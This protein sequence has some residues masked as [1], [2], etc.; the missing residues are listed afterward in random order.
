MTK[1]TSDQ[2]WANGTSLG[3][4]ELFDRYGDRVVRVQITRPNSDLANGTAFHIGGGAYVTARHVMEGGRNPE[5][6]G[7]RAP[8]CTFDTCESAAW[9]GHVLKHRAFE[10]DLVTARSP[11]ER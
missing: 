3:P 8:P 5:G 6:A 9:S 1:E 7:P 10:V 4:H 2:P 11:C